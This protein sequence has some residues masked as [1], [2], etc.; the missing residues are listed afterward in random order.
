MTPRKKD[1]ERPSECARKLDNP[2]VCKTIAF[3]TF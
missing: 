2:F 1:I 3:L